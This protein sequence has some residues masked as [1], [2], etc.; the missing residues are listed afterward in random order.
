MGDFKRLSFADEMQR[1]AIVG[2]ATANVLAKITGELGLSKA[3]ADLT[4]A[5][6]ERIYSDVRSMIAIEVCKKIV[7]FEQCGGIPAVARLVDAYAERAIERACEPYKRALRQ[8]YDLFDD[9]GELADQY[10]DQ[11]S[12][13]LEA[14]EKLM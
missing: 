10:Q 3:W 7:N 8:L 5:T 11:R 9:E 6:R 4:T 14:A 13:A 1:L 2:G 12:I